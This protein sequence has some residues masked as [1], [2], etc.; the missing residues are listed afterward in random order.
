MTLFWQVLAMVPVTLFV[1]WIIIA[2]Y[3]FEAKNRRDVQALIREL[4]YWSKP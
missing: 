3:R 4:D 2:A 1:L